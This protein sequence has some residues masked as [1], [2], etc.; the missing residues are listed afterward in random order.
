[1]ATG[2]SLQHRG[3]KTTAFSVKWPQKI[4]VK[5]HRLRSFVGQQVTDEHRAEAAGEQAEREQQVVR[6]STGD[7]AWHAGGVAAA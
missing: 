2:L 7:P 4:T 6:W 5:V 3:G 1:M